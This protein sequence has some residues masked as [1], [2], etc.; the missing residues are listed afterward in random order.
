MMAA[1][2]PP[3]Q[4]SS[5]V[6]NSPAKAFAVAINSASVIMLQLRCFVLADRFGSG[7]GER[8]ASMTRQMPFEPP[9]CIRFVRLLGCWALRHLNDEK[10][11]VCR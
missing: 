1:A 3:A 7:D 6:R 11:S 8:A 5:L 10:L 4:Q 9:A 2:T